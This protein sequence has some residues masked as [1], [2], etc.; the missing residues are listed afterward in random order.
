MISQWTTKK[1]G[2]TIRKLLHCSNI[3]T[4]SILY[5]SGS[6][7]SDLRQYLNTRFPKGGVDHDLQNTIRDNLYLRTVPVTT[8]S[9]AVSQHSMKT[10]GVT[11]IISLMSVLEKLVP[12]FF[13][14]GSYR[15]INLS[16]VNFHN[17][18]RKM[19]NVLA[20]LYSPMSFREG[21]KNSC[22]VN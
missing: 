14:S 8:R 13:Q 2:R 17:L 15:I 18:R 21:F 1:C 19:N 3:Y 12:I 4:V 6:I 22:S 20:L 10:Q 7:T 9:V 5:L 16:L 11:F